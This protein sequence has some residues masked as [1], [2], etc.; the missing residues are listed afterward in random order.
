MNGKD[1]ILLIFIICCYSFLSAQYLK[2]D[3]ERTDLIDVNLS[4][5]SKEFQDKVNE[6]RKVPQK[7]V[8]YYADGNAFYKSIPR[9]SFSHNAGDTRK[10]ENTVVHKREVYK[11]DELK[12]YY[13]K[14]DKGIYGYY[15]FPDLKEEF[16]GYKE[17]K[18]SK[19]DYKNETIQI[20]NYPCK[21]VEVSFE[22]MPATIYKIWYTEDIPIV[23]G[24][25]GFNVFPGLV[26]RVECETF[27]LTAVKIS[28]DGKLSD[29]EKIDPKLK[30]Y[31]NE[32]LDSKMRDVMERVGKTTTE[33]IR[34]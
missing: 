26:L 33:E 7:F 8:L 32:E 12:V 15:N 28:N 29:V 34:L 6:N 30:I 20:D 14:N 3:Y 23:A 22:H 25:N 27:V 21:L 10:D 19:I 17:S 9:A 16:Y 18:F 13:K 4:G 1:K 31:K 2:V 11:D 5:V 24:P